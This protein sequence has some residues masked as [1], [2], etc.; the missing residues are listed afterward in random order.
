MK[1]FAPMKT[2]LGVQ[3][4]LVTVDLYK[5]RWYGALKRGWNRTETMPRGHFNAPQDITDKQL[6]EL[7]AE[8]KRLLKDPLTNKIVGVEWHRPHG[9]ANE[10]W[11]C[12]VGAN[13][14]VDIVAYQLCIEYFDLEVI[15]WGQFWDYIEDNEIYFRA[16]QVID[17]G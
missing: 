10:L 3:A 1:E 7:T 15:N 8:T 9:V 14:A 13:A 2:S 4:Y 6:K 17:V 16:G 11:D 5:D 12:L